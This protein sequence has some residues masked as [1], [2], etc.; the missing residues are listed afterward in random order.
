MTSATNS[1]GKVN[2][3]HKLYKEP[4]G[5]RRIGADDIGNFVAHGIEVFLIGH[6]CN[7][8]ACIIS[9]LHVTGFALLNGLK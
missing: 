4:A 1:N 3:W 7:P 9:G 8:T 6:G 2:K 5:S